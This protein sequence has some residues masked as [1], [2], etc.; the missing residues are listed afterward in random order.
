MLKRLCLASVA[1][2]GTLVSVGRRRS[3]RV[4]LPI[5][6]AML[7]VAVVAWADPPVRNASV[8]LPNPYAHGK[9]KS[10][11]QAAARTARK[12]LAPLL[13]KPTVLTKV[14]VKSCKPAKPVH[15][16]TVYRLCVVK[17]DG[18]AAYCTLKAHVRLFDS[19]RFSTRASTLRCH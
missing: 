11:E 5:M 14:S 13:N 19:G 3:M 1:R 17:V 15:S 12:Y 10:V 4:I 8:P 2:L 7:A 16:R 6:L 9:A 18:P